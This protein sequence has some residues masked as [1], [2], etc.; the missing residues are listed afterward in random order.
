M[1]S[2]LLLIPRIIHSAERQ[3]TCLEDT[4]VIFRDKSFICKELENIHLGNL[5]EIGVSYV[6]ARK[7]TLRSARRAMANKSEWENHR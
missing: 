5:L 1:F 3:L 2:K 4:T 6:G 7:Y